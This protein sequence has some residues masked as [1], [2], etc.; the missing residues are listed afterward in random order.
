MQVDYRPTNLVTGNKK[1]DKK[2]QGTQVQQHIRT[3][4]IVGKH[5]VR[6]NF[7]RNKIPTYTYRL[8]GL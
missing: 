3:S 4:P 5:V 1:I 2:N 6:R 7:L 8:I